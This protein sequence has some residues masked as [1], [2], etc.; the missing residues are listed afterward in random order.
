MS[1]ALG[2][3]VTDAIVLSW[4]SWAVGEIISTFLPMVALMVRGIRKLD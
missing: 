3:I 4:F 1:F 2:G